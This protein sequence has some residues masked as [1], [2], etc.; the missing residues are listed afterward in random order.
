MFSDVTLESR[1]PA[2]DPRAA[3]GG[4][5]DLATIPAEDPTTYE[6]IQRAGTTG[7]FQIESRAQEHSCA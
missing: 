4:V 5:H 3:A 1:I 2:I 7:V 6:M